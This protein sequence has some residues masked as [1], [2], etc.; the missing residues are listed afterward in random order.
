[1]RVLS[2]LIGLSRLALQIY[3]RLAEYTIIGR[4]FSIFVQGRAD[5]IRR[6]PLPG[7]ELQRVVVVIEDG[8][9]YASHPC[10]LP[11]EL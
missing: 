11:D 7:V 8:Q 9:H 3:K 10:S 2:Y 4:R 5:Q 6:K 1:M